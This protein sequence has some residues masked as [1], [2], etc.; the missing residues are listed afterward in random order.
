MSGKSNFTEWYVQLIDGRKDKTIDDDSG[1]YNV[2]TDGDPAEITIYA[3]GNGTS[4]SNPGTMTNGVIQFWTASTTTTVDITVLTSTGHA[5]FLESLAPSDHRIVVWPETFGMYHLILPY[6]YSGAS[7]TVV[8]S[9]FD[10]L[11]NMLVKDVWVHVTTAGTGFAM[12]IGTSTDTDGFADGVLVTT[13]G[14]PT[15]LLEEALVST[16][17]LIGAYLTV[18][19]GPYVRKLHLRENATSAANITYIN[20]TSSSTAGAGYI[21]VHYMRVPA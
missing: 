13:T 16:S 9:G 4:G 8:D 14:W 20:T 19:T 11:A 18:A 17:S 3:D 2:L 21:Y 10:Q 12:D 15:T 7:E 1:V 6:T 5:F